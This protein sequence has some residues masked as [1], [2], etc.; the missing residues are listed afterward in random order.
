MSISTV[1]LVSV[2]GMVCSVWFYYFLVERTSILLII[3][4]DIGNLK[5]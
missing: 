3:I 4:K 1:E 5:L 2:H